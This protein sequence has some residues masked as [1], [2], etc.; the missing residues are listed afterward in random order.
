MSRNNK[1]SLIAQAQARFDSILRIGEKKLPHKTDG[2][3]KNYIFSWGTYRAY[4]K[5]SCIFLRWCKS[6]PT[7]PRIGHKPRTIEEG[8]RFATAWLQ[9]SADTLSPYTAAM[10]VSALAK[11][12]GCDSKDFNTMLKPRKRGKIKRSRCSVKDDAHFSE[13]RHAE[14]VAFCRSTGLRRSELEALCGNAL[15]YCEGKPYLH[16][17]SATKGGRP[18]I[19]PIIGTDEEIEAVVARMRKAGAGK[20]WGKVSSHADIHSY[21]ADYATRLYR[22]IAR[23]TSVLQKERLLIYKNRIIGS[24]TCSDGLPN[25]DSFPQYC[26]NGKVKPGYRDVPARYTCRNDLAGTV[27]DRRAM[28]VVS[29]ALGHNR[30]SIVA[31]H[32]LMLR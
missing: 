12:F 16:I 7:D 26:E 17:T 32:Y 15:I 25:S 3:F 5:Q 1:L 9:H 4:L 18:R 29:A 21:R 13:A 19:S 27:Y 2:S 6:Q 8:R 30:E 14:L 11:L 10:R 24:Y 23:P 31:G 22:Q 28:F 20:V